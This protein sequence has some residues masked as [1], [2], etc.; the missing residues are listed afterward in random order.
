MHTG[1]PK[2]RSVGAIF[3]GM[4]S[5]CP[6]TGQHHV[7]HA[8]ARVCT[9]SGPL[10]W[11]EGP[12][13]VNVGFSS[14]STAGRRV[15]AFMTLIRHQSSVVLQPLNEQVNGRIWCDVDEL[16]LVAAD[17][18]QQPAEGNVDAR[19]VVVVV[20][21]LKHTPWAAGEATH[22]HTTRHTKQPCTTAHPQTRGG[23]SRKQTQRETTSRSRGAGQHEVATQTLCVKR[24]RCTSAVDTHPDAYRNEWAQARTHTLAQMAQSTCTGTTARR[25]PWR[26]GQI[27]T[28]NTV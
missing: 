5:L 28:H 13:A 19:L 6:S 17:A 25:T 27:C 22:R 16:A 10:M 12:A 20:L 1:T 2:L 21:E 7:T 14:G 15:S 26:L 9:L 4:Y 24:P 18:H 8:R 11:K 23:H 3:Q